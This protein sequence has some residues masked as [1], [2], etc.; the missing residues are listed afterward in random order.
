MGTR[1]TEQTDDNDLQMIVDDESCPICLY[2][3]HF[4]LLNEWNVILRFCFLDRRF[5]F[6][7]CPTEKDYIRTFVICYVNLN[8]A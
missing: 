4:P 6:Y 3:Y 5:S 8:F 7:I 1:G 2:R